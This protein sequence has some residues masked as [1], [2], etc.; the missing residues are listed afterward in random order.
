ML[1]NLI[2]QGITSR[3][4]KMLETIVWKTSH[5]KREAEW[6]NR[7][8]HLWPHRSNW[9][10]L[11]KANTLPSIVMGH[12][13]ST[14]ISTLWGTSAS[15]WLEDP[16]PTLG[17]KSWKGKSPKWSKTLQ[18]NK[19]TLP[20]SANEPFSLFPLLLFLK[21]L[22]Y[23]LLSRTLTAFQILRIS[24]WKQAWLVYSFAPGWALDM[25][26]F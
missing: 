15:M 5:W 20:I 25:S 7:P 19:C 12:W 23:V 9:S 11:V 4:S 22:F 2:P 17:M 16:H 3:L 26:S 1:E 13:V 6:F 24:I 18:D 10:S 14:E 21:L 8:F